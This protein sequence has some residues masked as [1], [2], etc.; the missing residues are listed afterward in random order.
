VVH[1]QIIYVPIAQNGFNLFEKYISK[2]NIHRVYQ[3]RLGIV[4]EIGIVGDAVRQRQL[5]LEQATMA[6]VH[7]N[8]KNIFCNIE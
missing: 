6:V 5:I 8:V 7:A 1:H 4:D 3:R 2:A